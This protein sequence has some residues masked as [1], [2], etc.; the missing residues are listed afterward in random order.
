VVCPRTGYELSLI[1]FDRHARD[2][3]DC[4][5]SGDFKFR[6]TAGLLIFYRFRQ[7]VHRKSSRAV[8]GWC[9]RRRFRP[10]ALAPMRSKRHRHSYQDQCCAN[11]CLFQTGVDSPWK[12]HCGVRLDALRTRFP[13]F[14]LPDPAQNSI[15]ASAT[16]SACS[17]IELVAARS[18]PVTL[19][20]EGM[21]LASLG[22]EPLR[23]GSKVHRPGHLH[24][25]GA[26]FAVEFPLSRRF[27]RRVFPEL[28]FVAAG[29]EGVWWRF[30]R[31]RFFCTGH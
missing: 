14:L 5:A 9:V 15:L 12:C 26:S 16:N 28:V 23:H 30:L 19:T 4:F 10:P 2:A 21:K 25:S 20:A 27:E 18:F 13:Y 29:V 22:Y 31:P 1:G 11:A 6:N 17:D 3:F 8:R 7:F 24:A